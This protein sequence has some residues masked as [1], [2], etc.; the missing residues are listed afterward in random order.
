VCGEP[1]TA[2]MVWVTRDSLLPRVYFHL[3]PSMIISMPRS[4]N[5]QFFPF[6][7]FWSIRFYM[8]IPG[9]LKS[10]SIDKLMN[11]SRTMSKNLHNFFHVKWN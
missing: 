1:D 9:L 10:L 6:L 4:Y 7:S 11:S 3:D 8:V 5:I 2:K